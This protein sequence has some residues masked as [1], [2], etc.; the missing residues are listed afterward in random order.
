LPRPLKHATV[1]LES[2]SSLRHSGQRD[3]RRRRLLADD[4]SGSGSVLQSRVKPENAHAP[5]KSEYYGNAEFLEK[6]W[7]LLDL[8]PRRPTVFALFFLA[9]IGTIAGLEAACSWML[10]RVAEGGVAV[11][12]LDLGVKGSLACWFS[13]L[14]LLA[15]SVAALLV[16]NVRRHRT[17]DYQ[18]RYRIWRWAAL[19]WFL[20]ATDQAAS[21]REGFRDLM[22]AVTGTPLV[23]DGSLWWVAVYVF[24]LVSVG[25]RLLLDMR[26]CRLSIGAL[27]AAAVAWGLAMASW[28]GWLVVE[29]GIGEVMFRAGAEMAASLLLLA[30]MGLHARYVLLDAEG[31]LPHCESEEEEPDEDEINHEVK[32]VTPGNRWRVID[33]PHATPQPAFQRPA[34]PVAA[35]ASASSVSA[36]INRKLTKGER[37][38]L[39]ERLLRERQEREQWK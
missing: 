38:A 29:G 10:N 22:I 6:Q 15:A 2:S 23:G 36:P 19:C 33:P 13:S 37:K 5:Q 26:P 32:V 17:D 35:P 21:L 28:M 34:T 7:R 20:L 30:A 4:L 16:Y 8:V 25:S 27:A 24:M 31:R 39:K 12:A 3:D 11:V 18:G 14:A 9:G 1:S